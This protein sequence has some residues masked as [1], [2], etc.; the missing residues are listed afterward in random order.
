MQQLISDEVKQISLGHCIVQA[1]RLRSVVAPVLFG[2]GVSVDQ[3]ASPEI[4]QILSRFGLSISCDEI[5]RFKQSVVQSD[6]E[7]LQ[8]S[9]SSSF[10]QWAADNVDHNIA[11]LN[12]K[13]TFHGMGILSMTVASPCT[14][15]SGNFA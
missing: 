14:I 4:V 15:H 3:V 12:G 7:I 8:C 11:T 5:V 1:S 9:D 10:T 13:D 6:N 2:L